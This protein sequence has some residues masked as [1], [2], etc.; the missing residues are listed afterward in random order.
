MWARSCLLDQKLFPKVD[1]LRAKLRSKHPVSLSVVPGCMVE[2][3]AYLQN[4]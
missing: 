4:K 3:Q 1:Q 2:F